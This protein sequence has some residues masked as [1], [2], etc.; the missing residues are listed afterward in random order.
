MTEAPAAPTA[1]WHTAAL[2]QVDD[3]ARLAGEYADRGDARGAVLATWAADLMTLQCL[4]WENG[5]DQAPDPA[6]QLA[7]VGQ[8][9]TGSL[10]A[11]D[12]QPSVDLAPRE[13]VESARAALTATFDASV[14]ALL[15]ERLI[16]LAHLDRLTTT[17]SAAASDGRGRLGDRSVDDLLADLVVTA[18][19]CRGVAVAM[20]QAGLGDAAEE[21]QRM[22]DVAAFEA[23]LVGAAVAAGDTALAT[24]D[25]RWALAASLA[26]ADAPLHD[27]LVRAVA[28]VEGSVLMRALSRSDAG[29]SAAA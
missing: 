28:P 10:Q 17:R 6:G 5:L 7:G 22:A 11:V 3:Y 13:A 20:Q 26:W 14:H 4:L 23:H 19:D 8:A 12:A 9:V 18:D 15:T 2:T 1:G 27:Q 16:T 24:T 21:Q 25:L 29:P